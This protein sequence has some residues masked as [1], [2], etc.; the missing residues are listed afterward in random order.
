[1]SEVTTAL[2]LHL[3]SRR[4]N[5]SDMSPE[6]LRRHHLKHGNGRGDDHEEDKDDPL[7]HF[8]WQQQRCGSCLEASRACSWC[9]DSSTCVPNR[10]PFPLL[11]PLTSPSI[12]PLGSRE[13]WELRAAPLGCN[14]STLTFMTGAVSVSGTLLLVFV[15][16]VIVVLGRKVWRAVRFRGGGRE[17]RRGR[18]GSDWRFDFNGRGGGRWWNL[19]SGRRIVAIVE[20]ERRPLLA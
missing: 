8:C 3:P 6:F 4:I 18:S 13:R 17:R 14:V 20:Q 11:A 5:A 2:E 9:P 7:L 12:C 1:M 19:G 15:G 16:W 10:F